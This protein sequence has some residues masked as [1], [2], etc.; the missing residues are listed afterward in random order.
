MIIVWVTKFR[1]NFVLTP[2]FRFKKGQAVMS[3]ITG[4]V[5]WMDSKLK[6]GCLMLVPVKCYK[7][8]GSTIVLLA[9]FRYDKLT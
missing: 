2:K 1:V 6:L 4:L 8:V 3:K 5:C 7:Y 9:E